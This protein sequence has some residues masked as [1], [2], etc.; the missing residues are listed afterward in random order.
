MTELPWH[1]SPAIIEEALA[2]WLPAPA[3]DAD[4]G[5]ALLQNAMRYAALGGGKR[6][7]PLLLL[8]SAGAVHRASG[9]EGELNLQAALDAACAIEMIHAYS[10]VHD[11][12]PA[13]DDAPTRRGR[14]TCHIEWGDAMAI[15]AGDALQTL[16][17]EAVARAGDLRVV[18]LVARAA[19]AAGMAGGQAMD[20]DWTRFEGD[21]RIS[22]AQ[23]SRLHALKTGALIRAS[24]EA[25]A[26]LGGG[27]PTQVAA[28]RDYGAHLGRSFQIWDDVLDVEGDPAVTGKASSDAANDKMTFPALYGLEQ[29]K[30]MAHEARDCALE[31]LRSFGPEADGF[32]RPGPFR[33]GARQIA[34]QNWRTRNENFVAKS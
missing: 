17:I 24:A 13:M 33:G 29:T 18:T 5:V 10:L 21:N 15:L 32:A 3:P 9:R 6:T 23:L 14:A 12:L 11:D 34:P 2:R 28:L 7:R 31:S 19:G 1:Y 26:L 20:I 4:R 22:G 27:D 8:E 25:G 30:T 16:A